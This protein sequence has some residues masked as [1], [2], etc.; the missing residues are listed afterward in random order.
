MK[1]LLFVLA[2]ALASCGESDANHENNHG[3]HHNHGNDGDVDVDAYTAGMTKTS[4]G[5]LKVSLTAEP[6]PP[7]V[8]DN[9]WTLRVVDADDAP[10]DGATVT[11]TPFMPAHG[12]GTNPADYSGT[13]TEDGTYVV[14]PFDLFMPGAW[15][16]T[17]S[18]D[19]GDGAE[20]VKFA[21]ALEG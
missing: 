10:V 13:F 20:T 15:E 3:D 21:F 14:G 11:L 6:G 12:H 9:T 16:T 7:D 19:A 17:V 4:S 1:M 2:I 5:G 18:V 8:G